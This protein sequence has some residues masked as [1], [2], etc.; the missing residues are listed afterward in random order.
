M[1]K[2]GLKIII[3]VLYQISSADTQ[4]KLQLMKRMVKSSFSIAHET[5]FMLIFGIRG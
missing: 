5:H 3:V 2:N 4:V 1:S